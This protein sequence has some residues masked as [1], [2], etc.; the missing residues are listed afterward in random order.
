[1]PDAVNTVF[2]ATTVQA[3]VVH[4][5][6]GSFRYASLKYRGKLAHD[7]KPFYQAVNALAAAATLE[8]LE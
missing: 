5:I 6:R 1:M 4:L 8:N 7:L 2:P 3:C